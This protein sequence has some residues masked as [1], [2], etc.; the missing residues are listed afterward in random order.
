MQPGVL[1]VCK[2]FDHS[3]KLKKLNKNKDTP[4]FFKIIFRNET[5]SRLKTFMMPALLE[6]W[7]ESNILQ[8]TIL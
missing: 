2:Y 4:Q 8:N 3:R 6:I 7:A 1:V 5:A